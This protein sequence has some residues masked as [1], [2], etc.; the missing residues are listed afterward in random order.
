LSKPLTYG[1][2]QITFKPSTVFQSNFSEIFWL[3]ANNSKMLVLISLLQGAE[4]LRVL[5]TS[6]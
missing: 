6:S 1:L 4:L 2:A 5:K 3:V